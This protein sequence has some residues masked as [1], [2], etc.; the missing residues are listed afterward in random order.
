MSQSDYFAD[1][2]GPSLNFVILKPRNEIGLFSVWLVWPV[3]ALH[4]SNHW[5]DFANLEGVNSH[6]SSLPDHTSKFQLNNLYL[7]E[8]HIIASPSAKK[9]YT[10]LHSKNL[11]TKK[12]KKNIHVVVDLCKSMPAHKVKS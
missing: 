3:R 9:S 12:K 6:D 11:K 5:L 1:F 7:V 8:S 4:L 2:P 10:Y